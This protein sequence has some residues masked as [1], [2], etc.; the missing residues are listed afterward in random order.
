MSPLL[1]ELQEQV[2]GAWRFRWWAMAAAWIIAIAGWLIIF[3]LPD[4]YEASASVFVDT[5]TPL[6]PAL[7]GLTV[8]QDVNAELNF[9]HQSLLSNSQLQKIAQ[10]AGALPAT[11]PDPVHR[12]KA[13]DE[14]RQHIQVNQ[15]SASEREDERTAG[16]IYDIVYQDPDQ[17]HC[18]RLVQIMLQTFVDETL[19]GKREGAENAQQFLLTQIKDYEHRL[20]EAEDRL[21]AF[22]SKH[23]GLM[24][25]EQGGY[26]AQLQKETDAVADLQA[27]LRTAETRRATLQAQLHGDAAVSAAS[28]VTP[29]VGG[30]GMAAGTDTVSRIA[31]TQ[32]HLDELLLKFT[33]KHPDV[34]A[35]RQTLEELKKRRAAELENIRRGD[36]DAV[37]ASR[38]SSNPVYQSMQLALNQAQLDVSDLHSQ[39]ADHQAKVTELRQLVTTAPQ[40]EA[41]YAQLNRDYDVNKSQYTALLANLEKERLSQRANDAGSVRFDIV[42]SPLV[43]AKPV[44]PRRS[45]LLAVVLLAAIAAGCGLAYGLDQLFPVVGSATRLKALT[46]ITVLGSIGAAFP[47]VSKRSWRRDAGL[48]AFATGCLVAVCFVALL[49]SRDGYRLTL[50]A[51]R[52]LGNV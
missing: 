34:I 33:D 19:G 12:E 14:L 50:T 16:S 15:R 23:L 44:S 40:V 22:K 31:E 29:M 52:Q 13:I 3:A 37:A 2:R 30:L 45:V 6:T 8:E 20:R 38:A 5:R 42:Q 51:L 46:G 25:T 35:T 11:D 32:A 7:Q 28:G 49:L 17:S 39:L 1:E 48:V 36:V 9:V 43:S 21:A 10:Q 26:F 47:G 24:P 4:R 18:L 41:E 27:K